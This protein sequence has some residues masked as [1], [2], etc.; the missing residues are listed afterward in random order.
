MNELVSVIDAQVEALLQLIK[1]YRERRCRE[2][3]EHAQS[4]ATTAVKHAH[5]DARARMHKAVEEERVRSQEKIVSTQAQLQTQRRQ[6]QQQADAA[7]LRQAWGALQGQL[8]TRWQDTHSRRI[9]VRALLRQARALLPAK[10]WQIEHPVGW[11]TQEALGPD[12]ALDDRSERESP[13]FVEVPEISAGLRIRAGEACLDG[14]PAGLLAS[15]AEVE[16]E[17]LAQFHRL[18]EEDR[19]TANRGGTR[20][21]AES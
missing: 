2:I 8:V 13:A 14:T 15:R 11:H 6:R 10:K 18:V 20:A 4:E 16:A 17:L 5:R 1:D 21:G 12:S 19:T 3:L 9:W 7:L